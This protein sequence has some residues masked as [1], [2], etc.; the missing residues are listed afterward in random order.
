MPEFQ[1]RNQSGQITKSQAEAP[2]G[3]R[4]QIPNLE[5]VLHRHASRQALDRFEQVLRP[6]CNELWVREKN[7]STDR[8][9][10]LGLKM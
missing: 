4:G 10:S 1:L 5:E 8:P 6:S 2:E 7:I 3:N 9:S